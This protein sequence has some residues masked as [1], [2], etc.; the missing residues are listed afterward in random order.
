M[1]SYNHK[2]ENLGIHRLSR[3]ISASVSD[4]EY[5]K[6]EDGGFTEDYTLSAWHVIP[7]D[8]KIPVKVRI[9]EPLAE[10][11]RDVKWHPS[12]KV[13]ECDEGGVIMSAEVPNLYEFARCVMSSALH[14]EVTEPEELKEIVKGLAEEILSRL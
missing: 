11:F 7:G 9:T 4:E 2:Y 5:V 3:I 10:T 8:A 14:I 12:Q 13:E 1:V 6:S